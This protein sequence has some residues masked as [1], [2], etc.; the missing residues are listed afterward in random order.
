VLTEGL[1]P[2]IPSVYVDNSLLTAVLLGVLILFFLGERF[3]W[4]QS[5]LVVP[6]YL[7]GILVVAPEVALVI[8]IEALLTFALA[9]A[10]IAGLPK[11][12]PLDRAFGRDRFFLILL[13]SVGV[14]LFVEAGPGAGWL[15]VWGLGRVNP[16]HSVGLVLV[17]LTANALWMPGFV[18]GVPLVLLPVFGVFLLLTHVLLPWTNLNLSHFAFSVESISQDFL[19]TPHKTIVLLIGCALGARLNLRYGWEFGGILV[20]GLLAIA[21]ASPSKVF[22]TFAEVIVTVAVLRLALRVRPFRRMD[23][24]GLRP[25]VLAFVLAYFLK[26]TLAWQ[27][28]ESIPGFRA[29]EL[30]GF[31]YLLP[32]LLAVRCWKRGS[33]TRILVPTAAASLMAFFLGSGL[34]MALSG[35]HSEPR[36]NLTQSTTQRHR[37]AWESMVKGVVAEQSQNPGLE[38][39]LQEGL[40]AAFNGHPVFGRG[41]RVDAHADGMIL[42]GGSRL[43]IGRLWVRDRAKNPLALVFPKAGQQAGMPE[44]GV[45]LA[46]LLD[47][48][49]LALSPA[50]ALHEILNDRMAVLQVQPGEKS[51]LRVTGALPSYLDIKALRRALPELTVEWQ[52]SEHTVLHLELAPDAVLELALR[53]FN[54]PVHTG[55]LP[56]LESQTRPNR[57]ALM[58]QQDLA[59]LDRGVIKP[60]LAGL[61][62]PE[63]WTQLAA[64]HAKALGLVLQVDEEVY[65]LGTSPLNAPPHWALWLRRGPRESDTSPSTAI[66]VPSAGRHFRTLRVGRT[67]WEATQ[68]TALLV[69]NAKADSDSS[70][71]RQQGVFAPEAIILRRL[72]LDLL[73]LQVFSATAYFQY[74]N[75]GVDAVLSDGRPALDGT[76]LPPAFQRLQTLIARGGGHSLRYSGNATELRF[77]DSQNGRRRMVELA[78]G[79]YIKAYLSPTHRLAMGPLTDSPSLRAALASAEIPLVDQ[80]FQNTWEETALT[81][82][83]VQAE[84]SGILNALERYGRSGHPGELAR[85]RSI[86]RRKGLRLTIRSESEE[87]L[88]YLQVQKGHLHLLA[89]LC[90][91]TR[92]R[93]GGTGKAGSPATLQGLREAGLSFGWRTP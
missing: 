72:A 3:G 2:L 79:T 89:P 10:V 76:T 26:L 14:R 35:S 88:P 91:Y 58:S 29:H 47:A 40:Q 92:E 15:E 23:L 57:P 86:A 66:E 77:H 48:E 42:H 45:G 93:A 4:P 33:L 83:R 65:S 49:V 17:P 1:F 70:V 74:E 21:W 63:E 44:A 24:S 85:I 68:A 84:F 37:P 9:K 25:L 69:H 11:I 52:E 36:P 22:A 5:G 78:G 30:F 64:W 20:P 81:Q 61:D 8:G 28:G 43:A 34:S 19:T 71:L 60:L 6:G 82:E 50:P 18:R 55:R 62:G 46:K 31:G 73:D 51:Q 27:L 7:A 90:N 75:P 67:W 39:L 12:F 32:A 41:L 87:A 56:L 80:P 16:L 38:G 54:A 53:H 13:I 59:S